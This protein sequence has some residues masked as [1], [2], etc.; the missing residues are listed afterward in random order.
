MGQVFN[1]TRPASPESWQKW[2][3]HPRPPPNDTPTLLPSQLSQLPGLHEIRRRGWCFC[4]R[5]GTWLFLT[6]GAGPLDP[7]DSCAGP[8]GLQGW[9]L[10]LLRIHRRETKATAEAPRQRRKKN[11]PGR[12]CLLPEGVGHGQPTTARET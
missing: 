1:M 3:A 8:Q 12:S 9:R 11:C 4:N 5:R 7:S 10:G 2:Q 6:S